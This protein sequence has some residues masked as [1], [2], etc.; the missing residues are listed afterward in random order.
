MSMIPCLFSLVAIGDAQICSR[1]L[2]FSWLKASSFSYLGPRRCLHCNSV[3]VEKSQLAAEWNS[4][5]RV[6]RQMRPRTQILA[7]YPAVLLVN[8]ERAFSAAGV[9]C[10]KVRSRLSDIKSI[11]TL[12]CLRSVTD[13]WLKSSELTIL[14]FHRSC[15]KINSMPI[16]QHC[17]VS[18][19][20]SGFRGNLHDNLTY[21]YRL[22]LM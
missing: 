18:L 10:T 21:T 2:S 14:T 5:V 12:C 15:I 1:H 4:D 9:L 22:H 8:V 16:I 20:S 7:K 19:A 17:A 13:I 3:D 11:D 6:K